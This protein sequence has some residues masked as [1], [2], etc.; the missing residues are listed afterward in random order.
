M[1]DKGGKSGSGSGWTRS[2]SERSANEGL[3]NQK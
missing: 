3:K 2:E 1:G